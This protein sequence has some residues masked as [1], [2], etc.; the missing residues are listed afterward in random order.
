MDGV[1]TNIQKFSTG[2]GPGIRTT[3]F[4]KGC[5]L[6][7]L[8]CQNPETWE[9]S[10]QIAWYESKCVGCRNCIEVCPNEAIKENESGLV[11]E[12]D[13][14]EACAKC[15]KECPKE[16][17]EFIGERFTVDELVEKIMEDQVF[18]EE[19]NGG[20]TISGGE[21]LM[22]SDFV[23]EVLKRVKEEDIHTALDTSGY[24]DKKDF[25]RV[26]PHV[27][28]FLYDIKHSDPDKHKEIT[29]VP[30]E[31]ILENLKLIDRKETNIWIRTPIIPGLNDTVKNIEN[32]SKIIENLEN[33]V[34]YDLLKYN[35]LVESDYKNIGV[36]YPLK[37]LEEPEEEKMKNLKKIANKHQINKVT[38]N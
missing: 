25:E 4:M 28:L 27:D 35:P 1:I 29:E 12:R 7:C 16:A 8:W 22:Q 10:P 21:P 18:Y 37:N 5:P 33:V 32:I 2:D 6:R 36:D 9:L 34:K 26:S 14:C 19:S 13:L 11:S 17:R 20:A 31:K 38:T 23:K 30:L 24:A 3:V 15:V